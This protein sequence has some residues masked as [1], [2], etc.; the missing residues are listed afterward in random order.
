M[1]KRVKE[2]GDFA[3]ISQK[4]EFLENFESEIL[5]GI[6]TLTTLAIINES[7]EKGSYGYQILKDLR[8][9]TQFLVI[10]EGTLYPILKKLEKE[11]I[12]EKIE[13]KS[14]TSGRK[15]NFYRLTPEGRKIY[16]HIQGFFTKLIESLAPLLDI[17]ILLKKEYFLYCPNCSNKIDLRDN[18]RFCEMCGLNIENYTRGVK[19]E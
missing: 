10:E 7:G 6:S 8:E 16:H 17:K 2:F 19:S 9:K 13:R 1:I 5:R 11:G 3:F 18:P 4:R 15:R 14:E 12:L